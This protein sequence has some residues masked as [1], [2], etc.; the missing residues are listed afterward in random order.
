MVDDI[1]F[2]LFIVYQA[3]LIIDWLFCI[4]FKYIYKYDITSAKITL[5]MF[6]VWQVTHPVVSFNSCERIPFAF[7]ALLFKSQVETHQPLPFD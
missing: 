7:W 4:F 3:N 2:H 6:A 5:I 1:D